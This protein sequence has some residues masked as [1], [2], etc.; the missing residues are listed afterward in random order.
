MLRLPFLPWLAGFL[1]KRMQKRPVRGRTCDYICDWEGCDLQAFTSE[2]AAA[3]A[4]DACTG[5]WG[6]S[7]DRKRQRIRATSALLRRIR[8]T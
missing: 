2:H 1:C 7:Y 6:E 5:V 3:T 4:M 8:E